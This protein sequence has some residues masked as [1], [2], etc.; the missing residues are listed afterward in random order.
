MLRVLL[1]AGRRSPKL[2]GLD[3]GEEVSRGAGPQSSTQESALLIGRGPEP[4]PAALLRQ[5]SH[6]TSALGSDWT[7]G[8][9]CF[10]AQTAGTC[11]NRSLSNTSCLLSCP[12][13]GPSGSH[14]AEQ[15]WVRVCVCVGVWVG[16]RP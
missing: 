13:V 6:V 9:C 16:G 4:W 15:Q 1:D 2:C 10:R 12:P 8:N 11:D 5:L 7:R 3:A 14:Q